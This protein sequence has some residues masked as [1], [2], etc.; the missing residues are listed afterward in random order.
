MTDPLFAMALITGL[1]G[2]GHC[3]GMC[4]GIVTALSLSGE[5]R[6]G[7]P[8][9]HL[10]YNAGRITTYALIGFLVGWLGSA[11]AYT[12]AFRGATRLILVG[13]DFFVILLGLGTAG[14][15]ARLN[16]QR[17]EFPG[18]MRAMTAAVGGLRA[19]PP[20]LAALPLG[21]LFGLLPCGFLY[22][23]AI[24]AAQSAEPARGALVLLA[25]GLGTAPSLLLFGTATQW[26]GIRARAWM[27]RGAGAMVTAMG[28]YN[29]IRHLHMMGVW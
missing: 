25:F 29:L 26:L 9:F 15:F 27:L 23:M 19:L 12:D 28:A 1:L 6:R 16:V 3:L 7:G 10:L 11:V 24:T 20:A 22:A 17:L 13:S 8:A 4:G 2:S 5:G 18:P 14:L 21:L